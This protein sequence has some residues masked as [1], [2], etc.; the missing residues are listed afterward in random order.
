MTITFKQS[1]ETFRVEEI[2]LFPPC[3]R[4]D[5]LYLTIC[6]RNLST[7]HLMNVIRK[8][9]RLSE[10]EIGCAGYKDRDAVTVQAISIPSRA[11]KAAVRAVESLGAEVI[12]SALHTHKLRT[13]KLEGN[14]FE[15]HL[16]A[17]RASDLFEL[18]KACA[19]AEK[20]GI[21]NAFGPQRFADGTSIEQG[22]LLF[23]GRRSSGP[24]RK[25][26]FAISVF[27]AYI[28]NE[29]LAARR[30]LGFYPG[31]LNGDLM[32]KHETGGEFV[33]STADPQIPGRLAALEISPT[34]PLPGK[35]MAWPEADALA[36]E[37]NILQSQDISMER[38][39]LARVPGTRRFLRVPTGK[40]QIYQQ[41][42]TNFRLKFALPP[43]SYATVL[44]QE[45]GVTVSIPERP[46]WPPS[47]ARS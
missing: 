29:V 16:S 4:G 28:F 19:T 14:R 17:D 39:R 12:S 24:F 21:P 32:K 8:A 11:E 33:V 45:L 31:P 30:K 41:S 10:E 25:A 23:L 47:D 18:E 13:G 5:H 43:G 7:P 37:L 1:A 9:A 15:V 46:S 40:I 3:G 26:R 34:G 27:Q 38:A 42:P 44:L 2:P 35:K 20:E 36:F 22:R 6:K